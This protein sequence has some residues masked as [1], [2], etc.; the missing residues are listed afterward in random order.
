MKVSE[1]SQVIRTYYRGMPIVEVDIKEKVLII[2]TDKEF[3]NVLNDI[4][5]VMNT[6]REVIDGELVSQAVERN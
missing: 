1:G 6:C 5:W 2:Q 3:L 4:L